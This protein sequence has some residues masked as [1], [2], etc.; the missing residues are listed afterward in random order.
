M[1]GKSGGLFLFLD[2]GPGVLESGGAVEDEFVGSAVGV[3][4]EVTHPLELA[5]VQRGRILQRRL[6]LAAGQRLQ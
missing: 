3:G 6:D 1:R 5:A 2:F 4:T